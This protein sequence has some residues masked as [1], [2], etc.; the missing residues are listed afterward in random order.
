MGAQTEHINEDKDKLFLLTL[1]PTAFF[2]L[3]SNVDR[4]LF[5]HVR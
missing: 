2:A 1:N 3:I 4:V 5:L